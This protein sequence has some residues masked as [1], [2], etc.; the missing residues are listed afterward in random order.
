MKNRDFHRYAQNGYLG[1]FLWTYK[2]MRMLIFTIPTNHPTN[3]K[4]NQQSIINRRI[5]LKFINIY[6]IYQIFSVIIYFLVIKLSFSI[7]IKAFVFTNISLSINNNILYFL[8]FLT[9]II[10]SHLI[11]QLNSQRWNFF[12]YYLISY[13]INILFIESWFYSHIIRSSIS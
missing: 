12:I 8:N 10:F 9:T 3:Y 13:S 7:N 5:K 4:I 11:A 1:L 6:F 2:M